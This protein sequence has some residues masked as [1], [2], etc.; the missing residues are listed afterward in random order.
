MERLTYTHEKF[1]KPIIP[2]ALPR[3]FFYFL[4]FFVIHIIPVNKNNKYKK[5]EK[6]I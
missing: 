6:I 1:R 2:A 3:V 4:F 5:K